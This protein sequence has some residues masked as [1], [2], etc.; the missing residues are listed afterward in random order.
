MKKILFICSPSISLLDTISPIFKYTKSKYK[1]ELL[2]PKYGNILDFNNNNNLF[3]DSK[4]I[5][6]KINFINVYEKKKVYNCT[7]SSFISLTNKNNIL[8][9]LLKSASFL[10]NSESNLLTNLIIKYYVFFKI[11]LSKFEKSEFTNFFDRYDLII[12]DITE[13]KKKYFKQISDLIK[14][15]K[16]ISLFHGSDYKIL[17]EYENNKSEI[18]ETYQLLWSNNPLEKKFYESQFKIKSYFVTGNPKFDI[19][20]IK[21]VQKEANFFKNKNKNVFLI[22]RESNQFFFPLKNKIN[23]IKNIKKIIIDD[24]NLNLIIKLHPRENHSI[25]KKIYQ[26]ILGKDNYSKNWIFSDENPYTIG[27]YSEFAISFY[28]GVSLDLLN[29]DVPTIE[30]L[31]LENIKFTSLNK[32]IFKKNG[33]L[34]FQIVHQELAI[35]AKNFEDL[36]NKAMNIINTKKNIL[37]QLKKSLF[38]NY[39]LKN[40]IKDTIQVIDKII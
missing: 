18:N 27:K 32:L 25:G 13:E 36:K 31:N 29:I 5:F 3:N 34:N 35:P 23:Y 26:N 24:L 37:S 19:D 39:K 20:W 17:S 38:Q 10:L 30:Y 14:N 11:K 8:N 4:E 33:I 6:N 2:I 16:K 21:Y 7:Y 12:Y 9:F 40:N 1:V 15:K 22:S 28:S